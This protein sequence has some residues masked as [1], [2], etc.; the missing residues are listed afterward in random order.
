MAGRELNK[1]RR[2]IRW[3]VIAAAGMAA[4]GCNRPDSESVVPVRLTPTP[5]PYFGD[6]PVPAGYSRS[7]ER[8]MDLVS[9]PVRL[10]RHLYQ[11]KA[12]PLALRDF[13]SEQMPVGGWREV[14]RQFEEGLFTMRFEKETESCEVKFR[15]RGG[16]GARTEITLIVMPRNRTHPPPTVN[17]KP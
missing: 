4:S 15:R 8:S 7:D 12:T 9:G 1:Q 13:Y 10:V 2:S 11:G 14:S 17:R 5:I 3:I 16:F 6:I